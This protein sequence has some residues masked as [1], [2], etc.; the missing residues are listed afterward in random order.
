[1][2]SKA[3]IIICA[4]TSELFAETESVL[5]SR[6]ESSAQA[7]ELGMDLPDQPQCKPISMI[8][9]RVRKLNQETA[10]KISM[11]A[12]K[13]QSYPSLI[14]INADEEHDT[15]AIRSAFRHGI[16]A[17]LTHDTLADELDEAIDATRNGKRFI[18]KRLR[19][20]LAFGYIETLDSSQRR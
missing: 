16:R 2:C 18:G 6:G 4:Q 10:R 12:G 8:L 20:V 19:D 13:L 14:V 11:Y 9:F 3:Q 1:M 17:C 15:H 5:S 7:C